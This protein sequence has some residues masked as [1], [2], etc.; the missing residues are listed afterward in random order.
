MFQESAGPHLHQPHGLRNSCKH[1]HKRGRHTGSTRHIRRSP[2]AGNVVHLRFPFSCHPRPASPAHCQASFPTRC[3]DTGGLW[4]ARIS[5][6]PFSR[7]TPCI[8]QFW[9]GPS[10]SCSRKVHFFLILALPMVDS[11]FF[12]LDLVCKFDQHQYAVEVLVQEVGVSTGQG[13]GEVAQDSRQPWPGSA[14]S[15]PEA[16]PPNGN[17]AQSCLPLSISWVLILTTRPTIKMRLFTFIH[18]STHSLVRTFIHSASLGLTTHAVAG[19]TV[20]DLGHT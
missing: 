10:L 11:I 2:A 20:P 13:V 7:P 8:T 9:K 12:Q 1:S 3:L 6:D 5:M 16:G 17:G 14:A 4:D 19:A 15:V 18:S